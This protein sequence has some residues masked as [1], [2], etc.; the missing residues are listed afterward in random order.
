MKH[1][2]A[3]AALLML[4]AQPALAADLTGG[5]HGAIETRGAA[6]AGLRLRMSIGERRPE[7]PSARLA[8]GM[9]YL[10]SDGRS[11]VQARSG[12]TLE[13]GL[14][15]RGSPDLYLSGQ[16]LSAIQHRLGLAPVATALLVVGS[17]AA[18]GLAVSQLTEEEE[19]N[20]EQCLLP[21]RELCTGG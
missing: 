14:T 6:F 17:V 12:S 5:D 9:T 10:Q 1:A 15:G 13:L 2:A 20:R 18:S 21:E 16:R 11:M 4:A 19:L 3:A 8:L 7:P